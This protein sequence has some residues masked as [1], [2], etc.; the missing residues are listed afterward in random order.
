[1]AAKPVTITL[2]V[3]QLSRQVLRDLRFLGRTACALHAKQIQLDRRDARELRGFMKRGFTG[4][5][6]N[7]LI[8]TTA[9]RGSKREMVCRLTLSPKVRALVA[10]LRAAA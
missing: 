6:H 8:F 7:D 9:R 4:E 1:M 3:A 5:S 2:S 10:R